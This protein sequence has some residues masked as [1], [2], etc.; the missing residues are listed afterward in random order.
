MESTASIYLNQPKQEG[1]YFTDTTTATA[2]IPL[3]YQ[4][5]GLDKAIDLF[6]FCF[7]VKS[8]RYGTIYMQEQCIPAKHQQL[9]MSQMKEDEYTINYYLK[10]KI[11]DESIQISSSIASNVFTVQSYE[12]ALPKIEILNHPVGDK[13]IV[14]ADDATATGQLV[15]DYRYSSTMIDTSTLTLCAKIVD[16]IHNIVKVNWT[17]LQ[18]KDRRLVLNNLNLGQYAITMILADLRQQINGQSGFLPSTQ[19]Q[20]VIEIDSLQKHLPTL[21]LINPVQ[22]YVVDSSSKTSMVQ[23]VFQVD[24]L[25]NAIQQVGVCLSIQDENGRDIVKHSC[26]PPSN[27]VMTLQKVPL[28]NYLAQLVL[29][30]AKN[31]NQIYSESRIYFDITTKEPIEFIP[32]YDWRPLRAWH[33][34]PSGLET[35]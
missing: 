19:I 32:T 3:E 35:R 16:V 5:F 20:K 7:M 18:P 28:G 13:I 22:E 4:L 24:G 21:V 25:L 10:E 33:T 29:V 11:G 1:M 9:V 30:N 12:S 6:E 17:C 15:I 34:I 14:I 27:N 26:V 8:N 2:K 31:I 23:I